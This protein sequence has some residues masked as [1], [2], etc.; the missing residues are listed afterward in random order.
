METLMID[1][2]N[3]KWIELQLLS[4]PGSVPMHYDGPLDAEIVIRYIWHLEDIRLEKG[5]Q[6]QL[7]LKR[8]LS[9]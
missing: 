3:S 7:Q 5:V 6:R 2:S 4:F 1:I 8:L 9:V